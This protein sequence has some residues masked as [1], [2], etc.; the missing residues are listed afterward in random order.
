MYMMMKDY[1]TTILWEIPLMLSMLI[2]IDS[3][4]KTELI[5]SIKILISNK[6]KNLLFTL[7][8]LN[9]SPS[10]KTKLDSDCQD[11]I[12]G[13]TILMLIDVSML[14]FTFLSY[15]L[16][17]RTLFV[18]LMESPELPKLKMLK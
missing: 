1:A 8:I 13:A 11:P 10:T 2:G 6:L 18:N 14:E 12:S 9:L 5:C 17:K 4:L 16:E 15:G 7:L 3:C